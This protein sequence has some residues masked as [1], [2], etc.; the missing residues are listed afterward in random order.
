M[1][2]TVKR[3]K[4]YIYN[5]LNNES[6]TR[7]MN[8]KAIQFEDA[9]GRK[10]KISPD[11][12][13]QVED[14]EGT[15]IHDTPDCLIATGMVY[16][17]HLYFKETAAYF[18][19]IHQTYGGVA[20][21]WTTESTVSVASISSVMPSDLTNP[22]A[23]LVYVKTWIYI[24]GT[25][26]KS[27]TYANV[28]GDYS[29]TYNAANPGTEFYYYRIYVRGS[30]DNDPVLSEYHGFQTCIPISY[31][32]TSPYIT[33]HQNVAYGGMTAANGGAEARTFLQ[34]NGFYV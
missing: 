29:G 7:H 28:W 32:G 19:D 22:S 20:V 17:G 16:G 5:E 21:S 18:D 11:E 23:A 15:I 8:D 3:F 2:F 33:W 9:E 1:G 6:R 10:I 30:G 13:V 12:G 31:N 26:T 34:L 14:S 27:D 24:Q 4:D 25:K